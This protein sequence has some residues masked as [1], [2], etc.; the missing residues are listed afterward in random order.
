MMISEHL[1]METVKVLSWF[2]AAVRFEFRASCML[3]KQV[4]YVSSAT[5]PA[6]L[7]LFFTKGLILL[8]MAGLRS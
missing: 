3:A 2:L 8:S 5:P 4:F 6:L 1:E 7:Q